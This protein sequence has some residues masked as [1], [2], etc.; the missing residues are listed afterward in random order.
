MADSDAVDQVTNRAAQLHAQGQ[1]QCP[2]LVGDAWKINND[3]DDNNDW[4]EDENDATFLEHAKSD[5]LV[6]P[7]Q[8]ARIWRQLLPG[9]PAL[10]QR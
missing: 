2:I 4:Q 5:P 10:T 6:V 1:T 3:A 9:H 7:V 8:D